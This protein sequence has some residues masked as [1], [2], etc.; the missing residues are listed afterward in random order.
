MCA[1][2]V[3]VVVVDHA[4]IPHFE[5]D[6]VVVVPSIPFLCCRFPPVYFTDGVVFFVVV[7]V[8]LVGRNEPLPPVAHVF[9]SVM[10]MS[11]SFSL[12]FFFCSHVHAASK[13]HTHILC[14]S[15]SLSHSNE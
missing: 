12:F 13:G 10:C 5:L 1:C 2:F 3:V 8:F 11:F 15:L 4:F 7:V 14:L 6:E 9:S